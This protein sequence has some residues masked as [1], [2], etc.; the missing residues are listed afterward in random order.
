V[1]APFAEEEIRQAVRLIGTDQEADATVRAVRMALADG[2]CELS[3]DTLILLSLLS[4]DLARRVDEFRT[5]G[6]LARPPE[7]EVSWVRRREE[8][9]R[10]L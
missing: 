2:P 5:P 10:L 4:E 1:N 6:R 9:R 3:Q 7:A 8:I